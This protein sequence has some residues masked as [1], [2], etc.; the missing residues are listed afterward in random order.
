MLSI[1]F[2]DLNCQINSVYLRIGTSCRQTIFLSCNFNSL[3]Y[4]FE[5]AAFIRAF[6]VDMTEICS[7]CGLSFSY[8]SFC[9]KKVPSVSINDLISLKFINNYHP[10]PNILSLNENE[11][12]IFYFSRSID[13]EPSNGNV[14]LPK[15]YTIKLDDYASIFLICCKN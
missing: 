9:N 14:S 4:H 5:Q 1:D 15:Q 8:V 6:D 7:K 10:N 13:V 2:I 3:Q 11:F 12:N